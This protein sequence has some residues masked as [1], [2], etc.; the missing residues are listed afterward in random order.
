MAVSKRPI[1]CLPYVMDEDDEDQ[2]KKLD[3]L[4]YD[5]ILSQS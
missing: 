3:D 4:R 5:F 2:I 1:V